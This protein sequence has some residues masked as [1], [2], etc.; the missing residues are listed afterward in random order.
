MKKYQTVRW[1]TKTLIKILG[2]DI[3]LKN[4]CKK[5]YFSVRERMNQLKIFLLSVKKQRLFEENKVKFFK[6]Q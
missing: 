5:G 1:I 4:T 3:K 2:L 6:N